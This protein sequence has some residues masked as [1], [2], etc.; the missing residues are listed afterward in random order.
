MRVL[1]RQV[2]HRQRVGAYPP[3]TVSTVP[4]GHIVRASRGRHERHPAVV[5]F[6]AVVVRRAGNHDAVRIVDPLD[7]R[8]G[9]AA[10]PGPQSFHVEP[11]DPARLERHRKPVAVGIEID[12]P[13]HRTVD[14]H[15]AGGAGTGRVVVPRNAVGEFPHAH[16]VGALHVNEGPGGHIVGAGLG[17]SELHTAVAAGAVVVR[18]PGDQVAGSIVNPPQIRV[19]QGA[20][21]RRQAL[22][23]E[24]IVPARLKR[25]RKPVAVVMEIDLARG[26][27][28]D[29][30]PA[31]GAGPGQVVVWDTVGDIR[32][33]QGVGA[34][35]CVPD[36]AC[37]H[38][39]GAGLGRSEVHTAVQAGTAVVV[40]GAGDEAAGSIV[41]PPQIRVRQGA[42]ARLRAL[43]VE[44]VGLV[45]GERHRKPVAV[46]IEIDLAPGRTADRDPAGSAGPG[47]VIVRNTGGDIRHRQPVG[48]LPVGRPRGRDVV[49]AVP[50]RGEVQTRVPVPP[51]IVVHRAVDRVARGIV[52]PL[53]GRF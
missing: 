27:T 13:P 30:N 14:R 29:R 40:R 7:I 10:L 41:N 16:R 46:V 3:W 1:G 21:A 34:F 33:P 45:G 51:A 48:A 18:G 23:V 50:G 17:R 20:R 47:R 25:H 31:G 44:P 35:A 37:G 24:Q 11:V 12:R 15:R 19:P 4:E 32:R 26:R 8:V 38:V 5:E 53:Q 36:D 28:A 9:Q 2:A 6:A 42:R 49:G 43:Q 22:Q 52:N 39:V